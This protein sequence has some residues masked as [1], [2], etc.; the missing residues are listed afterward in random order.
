MT[1]IV[2]VVGN[3]PQFVKLGVTART[4]RE[5]GSAAPWQSVVVNTGQHYDSLLSDV[6]FSELQIEAP[7]YHLGIGSGPIVDQIGK[8][9]P[10]LREIL[11]REAPDGVLVYGDT[12]S[13]LAA[14]IAA[15]HAGIPLFHVEGGERLYRRLQMP[16]EINRIATDHL[17]DLCLC[18][19]RKAIRYLRRE[20][21]H[22]DRAVF[23]GDPMLDIFLLTSRMIEDRGLSAAQKFGL[24][25]GRFTLAT[26]HRA[27][28]T[29]D[30][31]IA[32]AILQA[33]DEGP[34]PVLLP[35]H[36]RLTSRLAAWE[37]APRGNL[38]LIDPL[39]YFEFQSLLREC[40]VVVSDSGGVSREAFFAS[41]PCIVPLDSFAWIEAEEAGFAVAIGQDANRIRQLL[42]DFRAEGNSSSIV[43]HEFGDGDAGTRIVQTIADFSAHGREGG[44]GLW[45]SAASYSRLPHAANQAGYSYDALKTAI[46]RLLARGQVIVSA[47]A[48]TGLDHQIVMEFRVT[49]GLNN[50]EPLAL[51]LADAGACATFVFSAITDHYN[52]FS[53]SSLEVLQRL[54]DV[55]HTVGVAVDAACDVQP[56]VA[57]LS[58]RAGIPVQ[59]SRG[60]SGLTTAGGPWVQVNDLAAVRAAGPVMISLDADDWSAVPAGR[61]EMKLRAI[62]EVRE[63]RIGALATELHDG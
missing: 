27:E 22:R 41:K 61:F 44:E 59:M 24:E 11:E 60:L 50:C 49:R 20:G 9:L 17:A 10:P 45:H 62:D 8:M 56:L 23:V 7:Q 35:A 37:W 34:M 2:T 58:D 51:A 4:L 57:A 5:M 28:N 53:S 26:I 55:G 30:P 48:A 54:V 32:K 46:A 36:P 43:R 33:L 16:E 29:D 3:R 1:K 52:L 40:A 14:A 18:S 12:N 38:R 13:T 6:F 63:Q 47:D 31:V 42:H 15:A 19:S 39:G 21:F 25:T